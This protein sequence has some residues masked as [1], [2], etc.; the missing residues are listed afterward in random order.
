MRATSAKTTKTAKPGRLLTVGISILVKE[1]T[2]IWNNGINQNIAFLVET[3]KL[4]P[5][6]GKVFLINGGGGGD[7]LS[8]ELKFDWLGVDLVAPDQITHEVDLVIE[9]GTLIDTKWLGH[10]RALGARIVT[11][12][13]GNTFANNGESIIFNRNAG[14]FFDNPDLRDEI[15]TLPQY[16][17][18]CVP[19]L[20]TMTRRPVVC[21]PHIWSPRFL[22]MRTKA[23]AEAGTPFG[24]VPERDARKE[25]GW[26]VGIFEPNISVA[27]NCFIPMLVCEHAYRT[28]RASIGTM[29]AFNTFQMKEHAT[30]KHFALNLDLTKDQKSW[31]ETRHV[32]ADI[33]V[34]QRLDAVVSHHWENG[35]NYLS[36]DAL[37]G[38]Y[39]LIHNSEFLKRENLGFFYPDFEARAGGEALAKAWELDASYWEEERSRASAFLRTLAPDAE[40]IVA[41]FSR[42]ID[43]LMQTPR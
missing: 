20:R 35:Q 6:V 19:M 40:G 17:K 13:V 37:H 14:L 11:F 28:N 36:Y 32:F 23:L 10:V 1:N 3:L 30:F 5:S 7:G 33:M 18:S 21:M 41:S 2:N 8:P 24:F 15:W 9:M 42:Q 27:K 12:Q 25:G 31:F 39:P 43:H 38:G 4:I 26:R 34:A 16:D 29:M 22:E